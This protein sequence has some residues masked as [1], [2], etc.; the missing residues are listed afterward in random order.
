[1]CS[2]DILGH[3]LAGYGLPSNVPQ[4]QLFSG[5]EKVQTMLDSSHEYNGQ[6]QPATH[7]RQCSFTNSSPKSGIYNLPDSPGQQHACRQ[8]A[9]VVLERSLLQ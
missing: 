6:L 4:L 2:V 1:M 8:A 7:R 3:H 9:S 5:L